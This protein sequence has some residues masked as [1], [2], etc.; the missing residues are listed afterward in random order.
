MKRLSSVRRT[1]NNYSIIQNYRTWHTSDKDFD[2]SVT[3]GCRAQR[4]VWKIIELLLCTMNDKPIMSAINT[5]SAVSSLIKTRHRNTCKI[6]SLHCHMNIAVWQKVVLLLKEQQ[7][8]NRIKKTHFIYKLRSEETNGFSW[9][10]S[11]LLLLSSSESKLDAQNWVI[12]RKK[13]YCVFILAMCYLS[14]SLQT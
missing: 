7:Q 14:Y 9:H 10:V 4:P 13:F 2:F 1:I 12:F 3:E 8:L 5:V 6:I 11:F